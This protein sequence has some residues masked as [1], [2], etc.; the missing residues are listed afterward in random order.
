MAKPEK[1]DR[2]DLERLK[3]GE[4][5]K[6]GDV[7]F[8]RERGKIEAYPIEEAPGSMSET[9]IIGLILGILGI[10]LL[11]LPFIGISSALLATIFGG[12]GIYQTRRGLR[13]GF[14][15]ALAGFVLG[16]AGIVGFIALIAGFLSFATSMG[17]RF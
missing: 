17:L 5:D 13:R 15:I 10:V 1:R 6:E 14:S 4:C 9:A 3:E 11:P 16:I 8:C 7:V 2:R 12:A